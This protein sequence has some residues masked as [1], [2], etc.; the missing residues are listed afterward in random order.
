MWQP[1]FRSLSLNYSLSLTVSPCSTAKQ[2]LQVLY[3]QLRL[4]TACLGVHTDDYFQAGHLI[5]E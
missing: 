3:T 2:M 1:K 4:L 5:N